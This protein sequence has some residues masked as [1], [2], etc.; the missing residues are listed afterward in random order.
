[1]AICSG[2]FMKICH[3]HIMHVFTFHLWGKTHSVES[4][5]G[6]TQDGFVKVI[7]QTETGSEINLLC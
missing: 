1:M 5:S 4:V 3:L 2:V 6:M 7:W